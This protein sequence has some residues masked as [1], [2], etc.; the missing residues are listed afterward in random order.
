MAKLR[1]ALASVLLLLLGLARGYG[2]LALVR[3]GASAVGSD[4]ISDRVA[5]LLGMGLIA[6]SFAAL[7]ASVGIMRRRVWGWR[8]GMIVPVVFVLDGVL[9]G[10]LLFGRPGGRGTLI[11]VAAAA[12]IIYCLW[13]VRATHRA[14]YRGNRA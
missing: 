6:V 8:L 13:V 12:L 11:N 3:H 9:N 14:R 5:T 7:M 1:L 4:R 10:F 2:G